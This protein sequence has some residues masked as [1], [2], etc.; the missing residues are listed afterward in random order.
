MASFMK[1]CN[2]RISCCII[3]KTGNDCNKIF[4]NINDPGY[5]I[6]AQE[7]YQVNFP[8]SNQNVYRIYKNT[9]K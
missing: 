9:N 3:K 7:N 1:Q 6:P 8:K 4:R 2:I 5:S